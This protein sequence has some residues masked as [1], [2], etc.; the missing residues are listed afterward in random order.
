MCHEVK[1]FHVPPKVTVGSE[2][3]FGMTES[4]RWRGYAGVRDIFHGKTFV[5]N[6]TTPY[7]TFGSAANKRTAAVDE[8]TYIGN[9]MMV[10]KTS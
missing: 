8:K 3:F 1:K 2:I 7:F 5:I 6:A 4:M 9:V 10:L